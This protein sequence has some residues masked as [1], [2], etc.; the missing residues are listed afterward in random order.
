M[1]K[2][3]SA[4]RVYE[5]E[6]P[7]YVKPAW[8]VVAESHQL[9]SKPKQVTLGGIPVVLFRDPQSG[10]VN[11]L[12]DRCPHRNTPLSMGRVIDSGL[13]CG[14]H[15]WVFAGDGTCKHVPALASN[16]SK[17]NRNVSKYATRELDGYIWVF[18]RANAEPEVEPFRVPHLEDPAY[19]SVRITIDKEAALL[20][21]A[22]NSLDTIHTAYLHGGIFRKPAKRRAHE[23]KVKLAR[24]SEY[25]EAEYVGE[26]PP[27]SIMG[28]LFRPANGDVF[29]H[30]DRF[31]FPAITYTEY[32]LA[33]RGHMIVIEYLSPVAE[34]LTRAFTILVFRFPRP[35]AVSKPI[36]R[37]LAT[38]VFVQDAEI[39]KAQTVSLEQ[40]DETS[41][42]STELDV[43]GPHIKKILRQTHPT[44]SEDVGW[45]REF[46]F[47]V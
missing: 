12:L 6:T 23:L 9:T 19:S 46:T 43:M 38:R 26:A 11:A 36:L 34:H 13:Q 42:V 21:V 47:L 41:H 5:A 10:S 39:L 2:L 24:T 28:W 22:E 44:A 3:R 15:G 37:W 35:V 45:S 16:V 14:Y 32:A 17:S 20:A 40:F 33:D 25:V 1:S 27:K 31:V 4:L 7:D 29:H 8:Y 30:V 18:G